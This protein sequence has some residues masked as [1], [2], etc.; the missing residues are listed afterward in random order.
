MVA[1]P[2]EIVETKPLADTFAVL[3][4]KELQTTARPDNVAPC[5][6]RAVAVNCCGVPTITE[7]AKGDIA[8]LATGIGLA[9]DS[10]AAK[11]AVSSMA[12]VRAVVRGTPSAR[13]NRD[14]CAA[15]DIP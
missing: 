2:G 5:A 14:T 1:T 10:H 3:V 9:G 6:S 4:D 13:V 12:S 15:S 7:G 8:T 11:P